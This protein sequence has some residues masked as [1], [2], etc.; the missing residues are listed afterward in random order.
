MSGQEMRGI[1]RAGGGGCNDIWT[2]EWGE[3]VQHTEH[4]SEATEDTRT[5]LYHNYGK[6][7]RNSKRT[8]TYRF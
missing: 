8:A 4:M 2:M 6:N 7:I 1:K 3:G 5:I